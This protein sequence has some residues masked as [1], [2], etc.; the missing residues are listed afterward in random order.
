[1]RLAPTFKLIME[2]T[3]VNNT[4]PSSHHT[5]R[6]WAGDRLAEQVTVIQIRLLQRHQSNRD[7]NR[8]YYSKNV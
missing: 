6:D 7:A 5:L 4:R 1:M 2:S 8:G 3:K